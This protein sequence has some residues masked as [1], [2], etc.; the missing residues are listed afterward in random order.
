[1]LVYIRC[2]AGADWRRPRCLTLHC[3]YSL[4]QSVW[5]ISVRDV[6]VPWTWWKVRLRESVPREGK[7]AGVNSA[8]RWGAG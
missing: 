1:M 3:I 6:A 5:P 8:C 4:L 2:I 7:H